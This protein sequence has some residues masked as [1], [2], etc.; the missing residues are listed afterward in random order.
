[1]PIRILDAATIGRIAAGE[2]VERPASVAKELF[3]NSLDA[4]A[5]SITVEIRSGGIEY[6]RVTDNG[7]GIPPEEVRLAFQNHATSKIKTAEELTDIRTMGFRG[8]ALAS[9][10][11]V[12]RVEMTTRRKGAEFGIKAVVEGGKIVS[13]NETGSPEGT[14]IIVKDLFFNTPV[15]KAF[16]KKPNYEAGAVV[17]AVT[18]LLLGNPGVSVRFINSGKT[19]FHSFGDGNLRHA[20]LAV[21]G[22]ET[23]GALMDIDSSMGGIRVSGLIGIGD[24]AKPTRSQQSFF[25]NGRT[26]KCQL[27]QQALENATKG[28]VTIGMHPMCILNLTLHPQSVDINVHP[29]KLEVRFR[30]EEAMRTSIDGI[31]ASAFPEEKM[32]DIASVEAE[33]PSVEAAPRLV[34]ERLDGKTPDEKPAERDALPSDTQTRTAQPADSPQVQV[35]QSDDVTDGGDGQKRAAYEIERD[36]PDAAKIE[37]KVEVVS[38]SNTSP[39]PAKPASSVAQAQIL[40]IRPEKATLREGCDLSEAFDFSAAREAIEMEDIGVEKPL[41]RIVGQVFDTYLIIQTR[42]AMVIIDQHAAHERILYEKY[43]ASLEKNS[44]SQSLL[45]PLIIEVSKKEQ[46]QIDNSMDIITAAGFEV[47]P[48]GEREI[49]VRAVP[50]VLGKADITPFF[51]SMLDRLDQLKYAEFDRRR[52]EIMQMACKHAVKGSQTLSNEEITQLVN[53]MATTQ[54]PATCP[55]GRPVLRAFT[56]TELDKMFKRIQ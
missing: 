15:R 50:F 22:R 10:C 51:M 46:A 36:S 1:M 7:C 9:I 48:F 34:I 37:A 2:V 16:L 24:I 54:A 21:Y 19:L 52:Q 14:T 23:A 3:E 17:D 5:T 33:K 38:N 41:Y 42:G 45:M 30:D 29:N 12:S 13:L 40:D 26:V 56:R 4:G 32:L 47:E 55:H 35:E 8:E 20:A 27:L 43:A 49:A 39:S 44:A 28:R 18:K 11:A 31:L 6:L 53:L 25:I